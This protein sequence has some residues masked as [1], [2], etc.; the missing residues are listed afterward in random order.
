MKIMVSACLL[1]ENCKYNGGS[2]KNEALLQLLKEHEVIP[3]C[4]EVLGGLPTPRIPSEI[5][6]GTVVNQKGVSVDAEFRLGADRCLRIAQEEKPDLVIFK[7]RSPS[8]GVLQ[9]YDGSFTSTL[10]DG[11]GITAELLKN[12]GYSV[13]E[14]E[15]FLQTGGSRP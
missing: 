10:T 2:N 12:H 8:C 15:D 3:V 1:G 9:H 7:S 11:P 5:R 14:A 4:P 13:I 6:A